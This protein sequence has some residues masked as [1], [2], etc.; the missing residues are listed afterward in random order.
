MGQDPQ[1]DTESRA[2]YRSGWEMV[3][4]LLVGMAMLPVHSTLA[5]IERPWRILWMGLWACVFWM[6]MGA[7]HGGF[8]GGGDKAEEKPVRRWTQEAPVLVGMPAGYQPV[9]I[10][11]WLGAEPIIEVP[12]GLSQMDRIEALLRILAEKEGRKK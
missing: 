8:A 10:K 7:L 6:V 5:L 11:P 3:G 2:V 12:H 9:E 1:R 4:L